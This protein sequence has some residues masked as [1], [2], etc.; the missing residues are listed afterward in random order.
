MVNVWGG[1]CLGGERLT[2]A[3][4]RQFLDKENIFLW[5]GGKKEKEKEESLFFWRRKNGEEKGGK[6]LEKEINGD[7]NQPANGAII[8]QTAFV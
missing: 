5:R 4:E 1:E 7:N 3:K 8:L 2:I 6:Y